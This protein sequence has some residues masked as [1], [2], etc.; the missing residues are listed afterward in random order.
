MKSRLFAI[1]SFLWILAGTSGAAGREVRLRAVALQQGAGEMFVHDAVQPEA[2]GTKVSAKSFLNHEFVPLTVKGDVLVFTTGGDM[3]DS[4][5]LLAQ[6]ELGKAQASLIAVR[7]PVGGKDQVVAVH[8]SKDVFP[9]GSVC[10][11]NLTDIPLRIEL[12]KKNFDFK[13]GEVGWIKDPPVADNQM[14]GMAGFQEIE[15]EWKRFASAVWPHPGGKRV[16]QIAT[17]NPVT[18]QPEIRGVRDVAAI[19]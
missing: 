15:G 9:P 17:I 7:L 16:L 18:K 19:P 5:T 1:A 8:D 6:V 13:A 4:A 12:E 2:P 14:S 11:L 10:V 3:K